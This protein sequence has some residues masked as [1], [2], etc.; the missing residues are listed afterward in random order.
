MKIKIVIYFCEVSKEIGFN[1]NF[2][3]VSVIDQGNVKI[4]PKNKKAY[5]LYR[6][7]FY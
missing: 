2:N 7:K 4:I 5:C 6:F 1:F 3:K